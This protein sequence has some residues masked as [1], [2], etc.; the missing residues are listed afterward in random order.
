MLKARSDAA[1]NGLGLAGREPLV[2]MVPMQGWVS[3][4]LQCCFLDE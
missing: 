4:Q 2:K 1:A 3:D